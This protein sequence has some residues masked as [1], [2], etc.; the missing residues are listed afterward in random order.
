MH[1]LRDGTTLSTA[2]IP[3]PS[4]T[5]HTI[6]ADGI[7]G[8]L[9]IKSRPATPPWWVSY[10]NPLVDAELSSVP[11]GAMSAV[12]LLDIGDDLVAFSFGQGRHLLAPAKVENDFGLRTALNLLD[13]S[14]LKSLDKRQFEEVA[15]LS[16]QQV[17]RSMG[18]SAFDINT[19]RDVLTAVVG[20]PQDATLGKRIVGRDSLALNL[21]ATAEEL[22]G[23]AATLLDAYKRDTYTEAFGWIDDV[24]RV[25]DPETIAELDAA[26]DTAANAAAAGAAQTM[27]YLAAPEII[28]WNNVD[29]F[30]YSNQPKSDEQTFNDLYLHDW[31]AVPTRSKKSTV[32]RVKECR[33]EMMQNT[34]A[35]S[36]TVGTVY[37]C[38][39]HETDLDGT[40]YVLLA[41][42]W[43]A[44]SDDFVAETE[45]TLATLGISAVAFPDIHAGEREDDYLTRTG[46]TLT[47]AVVLDGESIPHGGGH[48]KI[49]LCDVLLADGTFIH[50]KKR[51]RSSVLSHLWS[52]GVVA[53]NTIKLD[54]SFRQKAKDLVS[55]SH[56][57]LFDAAPV[58]D[59]FEVTYLLLG[60]DPANP[61]GSLP[62]FSKVALT[63]AME[64]LRLAGYRMSVAAAATAP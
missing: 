42:D 35:T 15:L 14:R 2:L 13:P 33:I 6:T 63:A 47:D 61:C 51:G 4:T 20:E 60:A 48:S 28:D 43:Y 27:L 17:S 36:A 32:E 19:V 62:F 11:S 26:L 12:L 64:S 58:Q 25:R 24:R 21:S 49:E 40:R 29:S 16:R 10:L 52:Q 56:E 41:G 53:A 45:A 39:V 1:L 34:T 44:I 23:V 9:H 55:A 30:R 57:H 46:P 38:T 50:A 18:L 5:M 59:Q 31:L 3:K 7:T 54:D 8:E 22:A 37:A